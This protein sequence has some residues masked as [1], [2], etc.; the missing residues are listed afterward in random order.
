MSCP[1]LKT[2]GVTGATGD[3]GDIGPIGATGDPGDIGPIGSTGPTGDTGLVG[4]T[5]D[6]GSTGPTG[7]TGLVGATG[8]TGD[9]GL[10]GPTGPTGPFSTGSFFYGT[11]YFYPGQANNGV[12]FIPVNK[13]PDWGTNYSPTS[14]LQFPGIGTYFISASISASNMASLF[15]RS[16]TSSPFVESGIVASQPSANFCSLSYIGYPPD[17]VLRAELTRVTPEDPVTYVPNT[18]FISIVKLI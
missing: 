5:G 6:T 10:T 1:C 15:L 4:P 3:P 9:T 2:R 8:P 7:D 18:G 11:L 16:S 14:V 12:V 13:S 17:G